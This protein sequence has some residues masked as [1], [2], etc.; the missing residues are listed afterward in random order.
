MAISQLAHLNKEKQELTFF[1]SEH[2][3]RIALPVPPNGSLLLL[4]W[5]LFAGACNHHLLLL[6]MLVCLHHL[7]PH[8]LQALHV[9]HADTLHLRPVL[10]RV[11]H[12]ADDLLEPAL[13][14]IV[15]HGGQPAG[16]LG[17]R[18]EAV[19]SIFGRAGRGNVEAHRGDGACEVVEAAA[20]D[21]VSWWPVDSGSLGEIRLPN[22][23]PADVSVGSTTL[24]VVEHFPDATGNLPC[25][26]AKYGYL[27]K[28]VS[29]KSLAVH[30]AVK[31]SHFE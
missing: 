7:L 28:S 20:G 8:I 11:A 2:F 31:Y 30:R 26:L 22:D 12:A 23:G 14:P 15:V 17:H 24:W 16:R 19:D 3:L 29:V 5:Y 27:R 9:L 4:R 18:K 10:G 1:S 21:V 25:D 13:A 6:Q